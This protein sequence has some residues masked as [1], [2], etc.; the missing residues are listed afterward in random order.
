MNLFLLLRSAI[1]RAET[2]SGLDGYTKYLSKAEKERRLITYH[3]VLKK[4]DVEI[5]KGGRNG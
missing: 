4:L 1:K 5:A 2:V 3:N